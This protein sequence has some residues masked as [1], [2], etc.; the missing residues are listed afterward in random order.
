MPRGDSVSRLAESF[1]RA[2]QHALVGHLQ[3]YDLYGGGLRHGTLEWHV[4]YEHEDLS[5][6]LIFSLESASDADLTIRSHVA[7][8]DGEGHWAQ[9]DVGSQAIPKTVAYEML[10]S[11]ETLNFLVHQ[12]RSFADAFSETDLR[13]LRIGWAAIG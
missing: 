10:T 2:L 5:R 12:A 1:E 8:T 9:R 7:A 4:S 13:P 11:A 3:K 6:L